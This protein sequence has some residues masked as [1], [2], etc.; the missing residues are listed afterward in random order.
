MN[1]KEI[2]QG[3]LIELKEVINNLDIDTNL[4]FT[5]GN[6]MSTTSS[7]YFTPFRF[8]DNYVLFGAIVFSESEAEELLIA[9]KDI[10]DIFYVDVEVKVGFNSANGLEKIARKVIPHEKLNWYKGNDITLE[11]LD[12]TV[13]NYFY[14]KREVVYDK[15]ILVIG[16]GNIGTK[17]ALR[18]LE[19]GSK[20][21]IH[22]SN[23]EKNEAVCNVLNQIKPK[24]T[25]SKV[26]IFNSFN[27][28][29]KLDIIILTHTQ[30]ISSL[31]EFYDKFIDKKT[32]I[33]DVGK[34]CLSEIQ[35]KTL[36]KK[37]VLLKRL[38]IGG[39]I[40]NLVSSKSYNLNIFE[41]SEKINFRGYIF[42]QKGSIG[43]ENDII[44][45]DIKSPKLV[46]GICDGKGGFKVKLSY[47]EKQI[48]K[49]FI[50]NGNTNNGS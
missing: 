33:I 42:M 41:E 26:E 13:C 12:M 49:D 15:N 27:S 48:I 5:I 28:K 44:V 50:L 32:L 46:Y 19:R 3:K 23:P 20:I 37:N 9:F 2:I 14:Q 34:G 43:E 4:V 47:S 31:N 45:D 6:T 25:R 38:D 18:L 1:I 7:F 36:V 11:A 21:K 39:S 16:I 22:G 24:G 30:P 40:L 29:S 10:V 17:I 35:I 8:K